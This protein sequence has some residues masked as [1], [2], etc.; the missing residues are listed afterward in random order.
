MGFDFQTPYL[1][2]RGI[3]AEE[4]EEHE[5]EED[6]SGELEVL[7]GLVLAE[8]GDAGEEG[9]ALDAGLGQH[10]EEGAAEREVA[11]QE[12]QIP[13]DAIRDRLGAENGNY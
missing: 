4:G 13:Q 3:E 7:L 6:P 1:H 11:E 5:D 12:L 9:A 8:G 10:E 2:G